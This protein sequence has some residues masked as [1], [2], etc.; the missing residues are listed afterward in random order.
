[1]TTGLERI[2]EELMERMKWK[3]YQEPLTT[4]VHTNHTVQSPAETA[5][6]AELPAATAAASTAATSVA[7]QIPVERQTSTEYDQHKR[8]DQPVEEQTYLQQLKLINDLADAK[9]A[10]LTTSP[11][12]GQ[13]NGTATDNNNSQH[14]LQYQQTHERT[15]G[16]ETNEEQQQNK[17]NTQQSNCVEDYIKG[18]EDRE[19]QAVA[20][21]H[22]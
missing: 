19:V 9:S 17:G 10:Q 7:P 5:A 2:A 18:K 16:G 14:N 3:Q 15:V 21:E 20:G 4:R 12:Y 13:S 1:M 6:T 22:K 8:N 11:I